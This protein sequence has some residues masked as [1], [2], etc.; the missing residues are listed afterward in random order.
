MVIVVSAVLL[1]QLEGVSTAA[2]GRIAAAANPWPGTT[3]RVGQAD[4]GGLGHLVLRDVHVGAPDGTPLVSLDTLDVRFRLLPLIGRELVVRSLTVAGLRVAASQRADST[5][6]LL[7]PF[8]SGPDTTSSGGFR[9]RLADTE[10]RR[11]SLSARY[12]ASADSVLRVEGLT[13]R[14]DTLTW[15]RPTTVVLDTLDARILP[16]AR[17]RSAARVAGAFRLTAGT[18][19]TEGIRLVSDS[20]DVYARG[21]L[22]LPDS[23]V[24]ARDIDF[25]LTASPL[26]FRD[27]GALIPGFDIAGSLRLD[28]RVRGSTSDLAVRMDGTTFDGERCTSKGTS[29]RALATPSATSC[30]AGSAASTRR[31]GRRVRPPCKGSTPTSTSR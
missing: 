14:L 13:L 4:L 21:T 11:A 29:P 17:P 20:S 8:A 23:G 24:A 30:G 15:P 26:D 16:P 7:A 6:D 31:C 1:L 27:V 2:V 28:A 19:S 10:V 3:A 22:L 25:T 18:L 5:W 12:V 9:V